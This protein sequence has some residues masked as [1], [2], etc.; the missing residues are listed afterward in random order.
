M[1][2][3]LHYAWKN[4]LYA[5]GTLV[6]AGNIPISVI[7]AGIQNTDAG[8]DFFNAKIKIGE[9]TWA[10][11]VEIHEKASDWMR[12]HHDKDKAYD[13]VILHLVEQHDATVCRTNGEVIPQALFVI[14]PQVK[15]NIEWLLS[16]DASIPCLPRLRE[17]DSITVSTWV[18][19]LLVERLER[20]TKDILLLLEQ[21]NNDWNEVFYITL[22]R[23]F[24][25]GINSDAF[26][27]LAKS[28][29]YH[30]ILKQRYSHSQIEAMLFGQAGMLNEVL[31]AH[32]YRFLQE[33]YKF[34][35][36]K[37]GLQP[38]DASLFKNMRTRPSNF[39]HLKIAQLASILVVHDTLFSRILAEEKPEEIKNLF[40]LPP[41][42]YWET[43]YHFCDTQHAPVKK[44]IGDSALNVLFI[45]A[46]VPILFAYGQKNK[47]TEYCERAMD[48]LE[49]LPPE[50]NQIVIAFKNN[51]IPVK[52]AGDSQALIQLKR[53]YCEKKK[54]LYCRIGF[55]L[56]KRSCLKKEE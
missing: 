41:S 27:R 48:L 2:R 33:E 10:G 29:P 38:L 49:S 37:Y 3:F 42:E 36:Q 34:F 53:E 20:K 51:G 23:A 1:E 26:E 25:F 44:M 35:R 55:R 56:L 40:R 9:T 14:P 52:H 19:A 46:V 7:D 31:H 17:I 6:T 32:H 45:N 13:S 24:G 30:C 11:C 50:V 15:W 5:P 4:K 22:A 39:P 8:P 12:H 43:H 28:L 54:C 16:R 18:G 47:Q 21:Y